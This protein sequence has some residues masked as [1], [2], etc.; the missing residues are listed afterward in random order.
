[1]EIF[2]IATQA[3]KYGF[4]FYKDERTR[5]L[6]LILAGLAIV[7]QLISVFI[8]QTAINALILTAFFIATVYIQFA[9]ACRAVEAKRGKQVKATVTN[10][11]KYVLLALAVGI[12]AFF[13]YQDKK[14]LA[15]L[16]SSV[17]VIAF[18]ISFLPAL[19]LG[20]VLLLVYLI[21]VTRNSVRLSLAAFYYIE[22]GFNGIGNAIATSWNITAGK[23]LSLI[24]IQAIVGVF[25]FVVALFAGI[26]VIIASLVLVVVGAMTSTATGS[27]LI[28]ILLG[29]PT[30]LSS[31]IQY[32]ISAVVVYAA[33]FVYDVVASGK[34][35]PQ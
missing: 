25:C 27:P 10:A 35:S 21:V 28:G 3:L 34:E 31:L 16:A 7:Q 29:I 15:L 13:S 33:T 6:L 5:K 30:V 17:L 4:D 1:M 32:C 14:W 8:L 23:A 19:I 22:N 9:I 24:I 18:G 2:S 12:S 11:V 26:G 20:I